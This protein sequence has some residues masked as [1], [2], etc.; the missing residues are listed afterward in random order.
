MKCWFLDET[1]EP[2][3]KPLTAEQRREP[4]NKL[5]P[6]NRELMQLITTEQNKNSALAVQFLV[7]FFSRH[8]TNTTWNF[9]FIKEV[10]TNRRLSFP[11]SE[12]T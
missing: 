11:S 8:E 10:N 4:Y 12:L 9:T 2:E 3:E 6:H 1:Q 7:H 5:I